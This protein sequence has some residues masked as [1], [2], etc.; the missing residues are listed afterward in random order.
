MSHVAPAQDVPALVRH[1]RRMVDAGRLAAARPLLSA[2]A[3]IAPASA[4][5]W[6]VEALLAIEEGR[7]AEARALLDRGVATFPQA[8]ALRLLLGRML[9]ESGG[10]AAARAH[11]LAA[12]ALRSGD[13]AVRLALSSAQ[14]ACGDTAAALVTLTQG[15]ARDPLLT[16]AAMLLLVGQRDFAN[17]V[18]LGEAARAEGATDACVL[19][20]LGHAQSSLGRHAAAAPTYAAA[21]A[22]APEDLYVRHLA[23]ASGLARDLGRAPADYIRVVFDGYAAHFDL[24]LLGLGYRIPGVARALLAEARGPVLDLGC[25]T[26]LMAVALSDLNLGTFIGVDLA[27]RMLAAA[28]AR[29]LYAEL[30][31]ADLPAYLAAERRRFGLVL[32]GDVLPYFGSLVTLFGGVAARLAPGGRFLFSAETLPG[33]AAGWRL[34]P[35]GRFAH[36]PA[37]L[38]AAAAAAGLSVVLLRAEVVRFE[39]DAPVPG[40]IGLL[41]RPA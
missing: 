9:L 25:G 22:L 28:A 1:L 24:H 5:L 19:G 30:F 39:H 34:G 33:E 11:L 4:E 16:A 18:A 6:E 26:G 7:T 40:M 20:L 31:E 21:L 32:A 17:A 13:V 29:G 37:H 2:V 8:P 27:P 10:A 14:A 12:L 36:A 3:R 38:A 35:Q 15:P 23:A 41:E